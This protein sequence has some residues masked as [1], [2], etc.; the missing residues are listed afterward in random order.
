M[1]KD[2][3]CRLPD[4]WAVASIS[5]VAEVNPVLDKSVIDDDLMVSFVPMAAVEAE[6]GG[7]DVSAARRFGEVK[8]GYT[9]FRENDI[10]FAKIT[11]CMENGKIAVVPALRSDLGFGST[12]FHVL[13]LKKEIAPKY[14]YHF[15]ASKRF[16][17]DAERNM[18]GAVGQRRVPSAYLFNRMMPI[19]PVMEQQRIVSKIDEL[20]FELEKGSKASR[21]PVINSRSIV[22][23]CSSRL[24][25]DSGAW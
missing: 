4:A 17:S 13:R 1:T 14:L 2:F 21:L 22:R 10:L 7:V 25:K 24:L 9:S 6:T 16:R 12:E 5:E 15:V 19:P 20:F 23:L 11:P 18:T 3:D 8:K